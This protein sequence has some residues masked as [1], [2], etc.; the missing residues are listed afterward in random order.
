MRNAV[1]QGVNMNRKKFIAGLMAVSAM[2]AAAG[3]LLSIGAARAADQAAPAPEAKEQAST[4]AYTAEEI[5]D[6]GASFFG[7][8]SE[9]MAKGVQ[10]VFGELGQPDAYIKGDEGGGAVVVGFRYGS[11]W[12]I[13]KARQSLQMLHPDLRSARRP[14][15]VPALPQSGRQ[16]LCG[17]RIGHKL[18]AQRRRDACAHAH[19]CWPARGRERPVSGLY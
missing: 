15:A 7:I 8:T 1:A 10:H 6:A 16:H 4:L 3:S 2:P 14:Q 18:S 17:G 11:G 13:R 9:A 5:T 19:R 12:L